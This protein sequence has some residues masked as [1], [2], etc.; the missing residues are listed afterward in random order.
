MILESSFSTPL[1]VSNT[2]EQISAYL[3]Q[4]GYQKISG[5]ALSCKYQRA[6]PFYPWFSRK[7]ID[8]FLTVSLDITP[9]GAYSR[10]STLFEMK[11]DI[12]GL[13]SA[14]IQNFLA[15]E[16]DRLSRAYLGR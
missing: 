4:A 7:P 3:S 8:R 15:G 2:A 11:T 13:G 10:L 9:D 12:E 14:Y 5:E 16:T 6:Y 1:T